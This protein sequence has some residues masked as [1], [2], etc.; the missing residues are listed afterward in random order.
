MKLR[1][2]AVIM[3]IVIMFTGCYKEEFTAVINSD[4]SGICTVVRQMKKEETDKYLAEKGYANAQEYFTSVAVDAVEETIDGQQYYVVKQT[5]KIKKGELAKHFAETFSNSYDVYM[6]NEVVYWTMDP[7]FNDEDIAS[8][9]EAGN[10]YEQILCDINII[11]EFTK[12]VVKTNGTV[13]SENPNKVTFTIEYD[14]AEKFFATTNSS[15]TQKQIKN[16]IKKLEYVKPTK[17]QKLKANKVTGKKASITLKLKKVKGADEYEIQYSK[18]KK[19]KAAKTKYIK[20]TTYTIKKLAKG[21]KYYVRV[22]AGKYNYAG[23]WVVSKWVKKSV[24]T[25]K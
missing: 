17:I 25:K 20:K 5:V 9:Q 4:G 19:F 24:T 2:M 15:I 16:K 18:N 12:P 22:R 21:Q 1:L 6:T 3:V 7:Y 8:I 23:Q 13:D 10:G 14:K 11:F